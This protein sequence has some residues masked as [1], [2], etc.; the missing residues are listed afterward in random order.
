LNFKPSGIDKYNGS[1]NPI[2]WLEVYQLAIEAVG[3]DSYVMANYLPICLSSSA[4]TWLM[5]LPTGSICSWSDLCWQFVS[6]FWTTCER[7]G[8]DWDLANVIQKKGEYL[9][10]FIP[11][12]CNKRKIIPE[13]DDKSIIMFFKKWLRDSSLI[14]KLTMKNPRTSEEMLAITNKY[15]LAEEVTFDN[16]DPNRDSKKDKES[17]QSDRP[18]S[19]KVNDKKRKSDRS[20]GNV[21]RPRCTKEYRSRPGEFQGFLD[22]ICIFH[23]QGKH[24]TWDC[25]R[26]QGFAN[27]VL[28][29]AKKAKQDKKPEYW[30]GGFPEAHKEVSYIYDGLDSYESRRK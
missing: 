16:R 28:R 10:E 29:S 18:S 1:T 13:V 17:G 25:D 15:T 14:H 6:N 21:E 27:E 26:L 3:G 11:R 8:V 7:P 9:W 23:L 24:K 4:R 12:F 19:S 20:V 2:E 30:K 22:R 5:G